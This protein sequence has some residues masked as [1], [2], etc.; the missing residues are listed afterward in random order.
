M[1]WLVVAAFVTGVVFALGVVLAAG[2]TYI[3]F[4]GAARGN[5]QV[6]CALSAA[7]DLNVRCASGRVQINRYASFLLRAFDAASSAG[8]MPWF[9]KVLGLRA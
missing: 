5:N 7:Y 8:V 2:V 6:T 3:L 9:S 4:F 1:W